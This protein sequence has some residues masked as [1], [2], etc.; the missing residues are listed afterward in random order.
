MT[1]F[2]ILCLIMAATIT[3]QKAMT[4]LKHQTTSD[5][6]EDCSSDA[7]EGETNAI[8]QDALAYE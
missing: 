6:D 4:N 8:L 5:E 3:G 1:R 2:T 7:F